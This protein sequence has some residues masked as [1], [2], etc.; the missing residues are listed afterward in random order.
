MKRSVDELALFGGP[1]A[2]QEPRVVGRPNVGDRDR[3]LQR[4]AGVIDTRRLTNNGPLVQEFERR[5]A[6]LLDVRHCIAVCNG[7]TGLEI[8]IRALGLSGEVI[9]PSLTFVATAHALRWQQIRPVFCDIDP[10]SHTIDPSRVEALIT[11]C[12]TGIIGVHL[13]GRPCDVEALADVARRH[14]LKLLYDAAHAFSCSRRGRMIGNFGSAEVF[15]FHA[16]KV[17]N[18]FEGG[19][20]VTNDDDL[21]SKVRL[22]R[23]FGL[24]ALACAQD[25]GVNG[26][27][28]EA[29][30]AMGITSLESIEEFVAANHR[31]YQRY[32][33]ELMDVAGV[34]LAAY[35]EREK[36]NYQY[37]VLELDEARAGITR[38]QLVDVLWGENVQARRYFYPGCHLMEPYRSDAPGGRWAL[39]HTERVAAG[40]ICLPTGAGVTLGDIQAI[41]GIVR[42]AVLQA[43]GIRRRW[44]TRR[45]VAQLV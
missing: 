33:Q 10:E 6:D 8:A 3:L 34:R 11:P 38:D 7:T 14:N 24:D 40:L 26:K 43:E 1:P 45:S 17:V 20:V 12:T 23:N 27:M 18:A 32:Q 29:S 37:V 31:K 25:V 42:L 21:A 36:A 30:A 35:D 15:S 19:A 22:M 41:C 2:F 9:I 16:T 4:I 28:S 13:W 44:S 5:I 39:P